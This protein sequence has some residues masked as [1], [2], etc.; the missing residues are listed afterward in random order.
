MTTYYA[1]VSVTYFVQYEGTSISVAVIYETQQRKRAHAVVSLGE[2]EEGL[3]TVK[4]S[5]WLGMG[6][7][8]G[9]GKREAEE[10]P[11][12]RRKKAFGN[13]QGQKERPRR[14]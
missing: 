5:E 1:A 6:G 3:G 14:F 4:R 7:Q 12:D 13:S 11:K 9:G 2:D 10:G 8:E